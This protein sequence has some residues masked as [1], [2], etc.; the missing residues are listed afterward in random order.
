MNKYFWILICLVGIGIFIIVKLSPRIAT[1][2]TVHSA[3]SSQINKSATLDLLFV[4][5]VMGHKPSMRVPYQ[6]NSNSYNYIPAFQYA[7]PY[8]EK[9]DLA[10][11]NL[12]VSLSDKPPYTGYP[13]FVSP[14]ELAVA[15]K[16]VGFDV[17]AM[18]NNHVNDAG[19]KGLIRTTHILD[20]LGFL[21]TGAFQDHA[22][23]QKL[24]PLMIHKEKDGISFKIAVLNYTYSTNGLPTRAPTEVN[25]IDPTAIVA[26][27][28]FA[29]IQKPDIIIAFMH[30][31]EEYSRKPNKEQERLAEMM[32]EN[33]VDWVIGAHPHV[34]QPIVRKEVAGKPVFGA[35]SLGNFISTQVKN[36]TDVGRMANLKLHKD[37]KGNVHWTEEK[38]LYVWRYFRPFAKGYNTFVE[39]E[40]N[41]APNFL[42]LSDFEQMKRKI[43]EHHAFFSESR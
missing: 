36:F 21:R 41:P 13:Q 37:A 33:G 6:A 28:S 9:A 5:D 18:A 3:T 43:Q 19:A 14:S 12:E 40:T 15:L 11:A 23:K 22:E 31:G 35:F 30:W 2:E 24:N 7:K 42:N 27:I 4:G 38:H 32:W 8:I 20:N 39:S 25:M 10:F 1:S 16:E 26:D 17:L 29:K 34:V